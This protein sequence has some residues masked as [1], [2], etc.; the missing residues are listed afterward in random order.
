MAELRTLI[1][2]MGI[3]PAAR[4]LGI[5]E[6][7]ACS[8]A[9]RYGWTEHPK[10]QEALKLNTIS[11]RP[12]TVQANASNGLIS[13]AQ[14]MLSD[15]HEARASG[16][17]ITRRTLGRYERM[18][19]DEL[20]A[21]EVVDGVQKTIKSASVAGGWNADTRPDSPARSFGARDLGLVIDA[22]PIQEIDIGNV[23][24]TSTGHEPIG[25]SPK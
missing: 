4:S 8:W 3:R 25:E 2:I 17:R 15:S 5:N 13:S 23:P 14:A 24:H 6:D 7:T 1:P 19:D 22:E 18:D 12:L 21:P 9:I 16:I 11:G 10:V 20:I